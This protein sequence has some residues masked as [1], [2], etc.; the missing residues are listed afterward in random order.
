VVGTDLFESLKSVCP[1]EFV[2]GCRSRFNEAV[3]VVM[4]P[5]KNPSPMKEMGLLYQSEKSLS[6]LLPPNHHQHSDGSSSE[7]GEITGL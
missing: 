6:R 2:E 4:H 3:E 7:E 5:T 1:F